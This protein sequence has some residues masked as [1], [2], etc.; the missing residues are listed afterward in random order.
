MVCQ[1]LHASKVVSPEVG[2]TRSQFPFQSVFI[3]FI[4]PLPEV[5]GFL[6]VLVFADRFSGWCALTATTDVSA[7]TLQLAFVDRWL[8]TVCSVPEYVTSDGG[9]AFIADT[10]KEMLANLGISH[11]I[12]LPYHP[13]SHGSV[14]RM[15]YV[16]VQLLHGWVCQ[17]AAWPRLLGSVAFVINTA[18]S[19]VLGASPYFVVRGTHPRLPLHQAMQREPSEVLLTDPIDWGIALTPMV[20][21]IQEE[22]RALQRKQYLSMVASFRKKSKGQTDFPDGSYVLIWMDRNNKLDVNW[23]GPFQVLNHVEGRQG[24]YEVRNLANGEVLKAHVNR[25]HVLHP[26]RLNESDLR[27]EVARYDEYLIESV[28]GHREVEV[29]GYKSLEF[30]VKYEGYCQQDIMDSDSWLLYK[31][32]ADN[33]KIKEYI[34]VNKLQEAVTNRRQPR[35]T[36]RPVRAKRAR[37]APE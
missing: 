2:N 13:E 20:G 19:R 26:G 30:H 7:A 28:L 24:V 36:A 16:I 18:Y 14:E 23:Q 29:M 33:P 37:H 34:E 6:Y 9:G 10:V 32:C 12:S 1:K 11:R 27:K 25:M 4:G 31:D 5:E 3:D 22:I 17:Q 21:K 15:N 8:G 35:G